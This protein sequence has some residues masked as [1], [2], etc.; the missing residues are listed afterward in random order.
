MVAALTI[1]SAPTAPKA[2]KRCKCDS[3]QTGQTA[4]SWI[5][6]EELFV[7][8]KRETSLFQ[9]VDWFIYSFDQRFSIY[10]ILPQELSLSS[11]SRLHPTGSTPG[12]ATRSAAPCRAQR[13]GGVSDVGQR[14]RHVHLLLHPFAILERKPPPLQNSTGSPSFLLE[15][16][17][18]T[19][20]S[21]QSRGSVVGFGAPA[22]GPPFKSVRSWL[23]VFAASVEL[24][25]LR[26]A[27]SGGPGVCSREQR[28][29]EVMV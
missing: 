11:S 5:L 23:I 6:E 29:A 8:L 15:F 26:L 18:L 25:A 4:S 19:P 3:Q 20:T 1:P 27:P 9:W 13:S 22:L 28:I 17:Q 16:R 7:D 24:T 10:L 14:H 12:A 21:D 2:A